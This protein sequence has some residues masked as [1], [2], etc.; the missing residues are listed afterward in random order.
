[1]KFF[2][3]NNLSEHLTN[4]LKAFGEDVT[5]LKDIF[6]QDT[7]DAVLLKHIGE[8]GM[9]LITRDEQIRRNPV[10]IAAL[11]K[12]KV[13]TFFLGGKNL[14]KCRLIQQLIRNWPRIKEQA[15]R[16]RRPYAFRVPPT[17]TKLRPINL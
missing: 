5:H 7:D 14:D 10:E 13:G 4:G 3:D 11:R 17:G 1:M 9:I 6:P 12:Y 8:N 2:F 15:R 16:S